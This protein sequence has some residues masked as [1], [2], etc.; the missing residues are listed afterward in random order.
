MAWPTMGGETKNHAIGKEG[1]V[2]T[3]FVAVGVLAAWYGVAGSESEGE[4]P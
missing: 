1:E 3:A 2:R 4:C